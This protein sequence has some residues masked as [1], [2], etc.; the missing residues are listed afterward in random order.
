MKEREIRNLSTEKEM[1]RKKERKK[2]R[3]RNENEGD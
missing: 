3:K 1:V 2:E